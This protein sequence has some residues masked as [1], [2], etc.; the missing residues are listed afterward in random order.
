V[1]RADRRPGLVEPA[2]VAQVAAEDLPDALLHLA[3]RL[4]GERD[5]EDR[6]GGDALADEVRH[7]AGDDARLAASGAGDDQ[8]RPVD[9]R[10]GLALGV[11]QV[12]QQLV[13]G[14]HGGEYRGKA[15]GA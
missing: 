1:E 8:Q 4:V 2:E 10:C 9:V 11:S 14:K 13:C 6:G 3:G 15:L 5:G 12:F 7:A